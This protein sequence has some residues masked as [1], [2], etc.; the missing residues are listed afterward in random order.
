VVF[1]VAGVGAVSFYY[2]RNPEAQSGTTTLSNT[3]QSS[4]NYV[5]ANGLNGQPYFNASKVYASL[6]FPKISYYPYG[7][8]APF[9]PGKPNFT[10]QERTGPP[11]YA[12][13]MASI[14]AP[15][16]SLKEA[17]RLAASNAKLD[18]VNYTLNSAVFLPGEVDS[19]VLASDPEWH[20]YFAQIYDGYWVDDPRGGLGYSIEADVDAVN[21]SVV[22]KGQAMSNLPNLGHYGL[23]VS[24]SR[25]LETVRVLSLPDMPAVTKNGTLTFMAPLIVFPGQSPNSRWLNSSLIGEGRLAWI[26]NLDLETGCCSQDA[27]FAVDAGTGALL[28]KTAI[29]G[30]GIPSLGYVSSSFVFST[31]KNMT[32]SQQTYPLNGSIIGRPGSVLAA[33]P[34][35]LTVRPGMTASINVN[36]S[37]MD[38]QNPPNVSFS[39]ANPFPSF[40]QN[41][42]SDG[43]PPGV[44]FRFTKPT[45]TLLSNR[46]SNT[47]LLISVE[48]SAPLGTYFI[49]LQPKQSPSSQLVGGNSI[50][51][52]FSVWDGAGQWPPPPLLGL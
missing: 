2:P 31:A 12:G 45:L 33:F 35:V 41:I 46:S 1:V 48:R 19:R 3:V 14:L 11:Y 22:V 32:V 50:F 49:Q 40:I 28:G 51:F 15:V 8:N 38:M 44:S 47:T 4:P 30:I 26:I 34:D 27:T 5:L 9:L 7:E 18:P 39:L 10:L 20:L 6:G 37:A 36:V 16:L 21:G 24:S 52:F 29:T 13:Y 42:S 17:V 43:A 23:N 25:A